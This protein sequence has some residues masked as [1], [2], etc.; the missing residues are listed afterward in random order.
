VETVGRVQERTRIVLANTEGICLEALKV[1]KWKVLDIGGSAN[2]FSLA[3]VIVDPY[4]EEE[5]D[6]QRGGV[7]SNIPEGVEFVKAF[8]EELPFPDDSFD[9]VVCSETL[10]HCRDPVK[11]IEE[12][13]RVAPRGYVDVPA[14]IHELFEPHGEHL[15]RCFLLEDGTMG[16]HER[17]PGDIIT[18]VEQLLGAFTWRPP[19]ELQRD[20]RT[21]EQAPCERWYIQFVWEREALRGRYLTDEEVLPG[22]TLLGINEEVWVPEELKKL[23]E[24][25][26][27]LVR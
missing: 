16:F 26:L 27:S 13:K 12:M 10:N 15:W 7:S 22:E 24:G 2:A 21:R 19:G 8:G 18:I 14:A 4:P 9:F 11:V 1:I 6:A 3:T 23:L 25:N 5:F 20:Y 17:R